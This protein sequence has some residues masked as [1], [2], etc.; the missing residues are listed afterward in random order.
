MV[1]AHVARDQ[2]PHRSVLN[3]GEADSS[4]TK[5]RRPMT[6]GV[7]PDCWPPEKA[8]IHHIPIRVVNRELLLL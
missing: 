1:S 6:P 7:I 2:R 8:P 4:E 5:G 3:D